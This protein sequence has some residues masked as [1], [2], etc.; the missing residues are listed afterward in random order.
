MTSL[1]VAPMT[2]N[3]T[4]AQ[5]ADR[6]EADSGRIYM[7]GLQAL[8]R[9]P[10]VQA[11][12]D[13]A[14]GLNSGTFISGYP[15]SPLGGY[16]LQ[17][18]KNRELLE[19]HHVFHRPGA[20]EE[21]AATTLIGTQ[22]LDH[23]PHE[24]YH[25]VTGI[26]YGKGP[27]LDRSGDALRHGNFGGTSTHG[28][29]VILSGE[30]HEAKSSTLPHEQEYSF[31]H[32]GI[33]VLYPSSVEE[34]LT[35]GQHAVAMSRYS[36][37]WV[38]MKL[39]GQLCDGG[40]TLDLA[41]TVVTPTIPRF[42]VDGKSFR[43]VQDN[44]Y[45]PGRTIE[46][47]RHVFEERHP[48]A[49]AYMRAN[50][51]DRV[52]VSG[53]HDE[54]AIVTAGKSYADVAQ[55]LSDM[56]LDEAA[57][58]SAGVRLVK[59]G[60]IYPVDAEFL[61]DSLA[62]VEEVYVV[63]EKR[64]MLEEKVKDVLCN[65][66]AGPRV[67]GKRDR[68]GREL[69][70]AYGVMDADVITTRLGPML[71]GRVRETIRLDARTREINDIAARQYPSVHKRSPNYCSGCPH[72]VS[73]TLLE[74]Q[75]A[76][77]APGCHVF[78]AI[79]NDQPHKQIDA[80]FP[81]GGEGVGWIGLSPFTDL[82]HVVQ[83]QGDGSLFHSS[84]LNIR[85]SI[86]AG[87]DMTYKILFN[88]YVANTG[89]QEAVGAQD[90]PKLVQLLA[91]EGASKIAIIAR[92]P[93]VYARHKFPSVISVHDASEVDEVLADL[94][95]TKGTTI[96]LY[97]GECANERRRRQKRGKAPKSTKFVLINEDVCE[98]CGDCGEVTNCMSLHK[99]DTE[100]GQ[101][102]RIHQS[103][104]NQDTSCLKGDCPSFVT[105][106]SADGLA[107]PDPAK[108]AA[109][110]LPPASIP[111]VTAPFHVYVP[112]VGGTGVLTINALLCWAA[113]LD[114]LEVAS[115]D[116]TGAAQK[117][118]AVL[119]SLVISPPGAAPASNKAGLGAADL[120]LAVDAMASA[121]KV[122]L[123]RCSPSRTAAFVNT[124]LLPSGDMVRD[125]DLTVDVNDLVS[126]ILE[127]TDTQR[128]VVADA[129]FVAEGLFG[130]Y[131]STNMV[132]I[133][134][135]YQA[136]LLP[137]S[138]ESLEEAITVNGAAV[139]QNLQAFRYGRLAQADPDR[140]RAMIIDVPLDAEG[141]KGA[142]SLSLRPK[143]RA[144]YGELMGQAD[145]FDE[146]SRRLLAVR[147]AELIQYQNVA[148]AAQYLDFVMA[149]A[150]KEKAGSGSE[151]LAITRAVITNLYKLMAYKD[152]Y[153]VAR[154]HLRS[155]AENRVDGMFSGKSKVEY[156]LHPPTLR[157][158]GMNRKLRIPSWAAHPAFGALAR[159]RG[160][161]GTALDIFGRDELRREERALIGWYRD[162]V[163]DAVARLTLTNRDAVVDLARL[164]EDIRGYEQI[165]KD[166]IVKAKH[167]A[168]ILR[169]RLEN[170]NSL[171]VLSPITI[172][173]APS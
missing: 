107:K 121:D 114:G 69:F 78:A 79:M 51:L 117:W 125:V 172:Q 92:D 31:Q 124:G 154:L 33:P 160:V 168:E 11:K 76:W 58:T 65:L 17:L 21:L 97:D 53:S 29:V 94:A 86:A 153:E 25:G 82:P 151:H 74:G 44:M 101:K 155:R 169:G 128:T 131:M 14:T 72:N 70:P 108:L 167:R 105:V 83:N 20:N 170:T 158:L 118:G 52:I 173:G 139:A 144:T 28:A 46:T 13:R 98:N 57:L 45:Y 22:L 24:R 85:F 19:R 119:S 5:I 18:H 113:M 68:E 36:G 50:A 56:G 6:F 140:V 146:E 115:Y 127:F 87:V 120:Y 27:G 8:I 116:Q 37:L 102:T 60:A 77:G 161:R 136:G 130:D 159:M 4:S 157:A 96:F 149:T 135:A 23:Y 66:A 112:G 152:E 84:Y 71:R 138:A 148:Y 63:E 32:A 110:D 38:A 35:F 150:E 54:V 40:Q 2:S 141:E 134:M 133:G 43:K 143:L 89:A 26:W 41:S 126:P 122:N 67:Y 156:N 75:V 7:N 106:T 104:C 137:I 1:D 48:A 90:V 12:A 93:K 81:L 61:L 164:P 10:L 165:K 3:G 109:G 64:G 42:Q 39:V 99:A 142:R 111:A 80:T 73:T 162:L 129:K 95:A 147:V 34:F 171:L 47:E 62:D 103:S 100:F 88:G 166:N 16:D 123:D 132:A 163:V 145:H 49:V 91:L 15:G 55:S 59:L 30:D 9:F